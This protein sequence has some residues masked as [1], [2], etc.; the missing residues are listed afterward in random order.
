MVTT[1]A[2]ATDSPKSHLRLSNPSRGPT[3]H[4]RWASEGLLASFPERRR[5]TAGIV[6][7]G[8]C[9]D[10]VMLLGNGKDTYR[11]SLML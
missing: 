8:S 5:W 10:A 2:R 3:F 4:A 9:N 1:M 11:V 6:V 7:G